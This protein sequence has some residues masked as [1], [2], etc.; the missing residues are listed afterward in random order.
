MLSIFSITLFKIDAQ[1][2]SCNKVLYLGLGTG[3]NNYT[4]LLGISGSLRI[5]DK[6]FVRGGFGIG[7]WG[8]KF[9]IGLKYDADN[10]EGWTFGIGYS[11]CPGANNVKSAMPVESGGNK[12]VTI[13]FL[14]AS[15]INLT[16]G[17]NWSVGKSNIFYMEFGYAIPMQS[18][19]WKVTD[20]SILSGTSK[21]TLNLIQ[22]GGLIIGAGFSFGI[23]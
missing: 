6:L 22:P 19:S 10:N 1:S 18:N 11:I 2:D 23:L 16:I 7:G 13:D 3:I 5:H 9:S 4:A 12:K 21:S 17:H 14:K 15:T 20:G 8:N